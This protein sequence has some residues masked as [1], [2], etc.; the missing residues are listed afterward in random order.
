[1]IDWNSPT[2]GQ[3]GHNV[4]DSEHGSHLDAEPRHAPTSDKESRDARRDDDQ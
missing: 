4:H 1:M 3:I 2:W